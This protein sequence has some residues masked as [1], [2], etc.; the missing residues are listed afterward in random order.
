MTSPQ[1][2]RLQYINT[3]LLTIILSG[4]GYTINLIE[5]MNKRLNDTTERVIKVEIE[6]MYSRE[7]CIQSTAHFNEIDERLNKLEAIID[8]KILI[9]YK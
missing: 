5:D 9:K 7:R 8:K 2:N 4:I 6:Q 3:A 1:L